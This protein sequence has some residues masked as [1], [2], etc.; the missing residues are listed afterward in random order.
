MVHIRTTS[1]SSTRW[2]NYFSNDK[3]VKKDLTGILLQNQK[4][5]KADQWEVVEFPAILDHGEKPEAVWP[6]Y[7]KIEELEKVKATLPVGKWNAQWMQRPTSE[8]GA[9]LNENGGE[10]G[11]KT[12]FQTC[13]M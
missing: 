3:V 11:K 9:I 8:E 2:K 4:E 6:E 10:N 12:T 7:W 5:V 13:I 1:T